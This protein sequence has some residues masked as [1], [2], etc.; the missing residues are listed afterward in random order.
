MFIFA[1]DYCVLVIPTLVE[2]GQETAPILVHSKHPLPIIRLHVGWQ[3]ATEFAYLEVA[4]NG[5]GVRHL[6]HVLNH[7]GIDHRC[8]L[9]LIHQLRVVVL[10]RL[11]RGIGHRWRLESHIII[12]LGGVST[13]PKNISPRIMLLL[14]LLLRFIL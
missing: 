5:R 14:L 3:H 13:A 11:L 8:V 9:L 2:E 10:V 1:N 6:G 12:C 7:T 4:Q